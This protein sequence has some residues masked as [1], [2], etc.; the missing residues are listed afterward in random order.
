[1]LQST[2][3]LHKLKRKS[4]YFVKTASARLNNDNIK[5]LVGMVVLGTCRVGVDCCKAW[6]DRYVM[7]PTCGLHQQLYSRACTAQLRD[8]LRA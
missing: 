1:M 7:W 8:L 4:V 6:N 5:T 3:P 2:K